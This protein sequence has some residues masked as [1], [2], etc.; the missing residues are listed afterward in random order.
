MS[1]PSRAEVIETL[2][3]LD[4]DR[5]RAESAADDP[6]LAW[7]DDAL[8]ACIDDVVTS[9]SRKINHPGLALWS[10]YLSKGA[11]PPSQAKAKGKQAHT[12]QL[13]RCP[14]P[15]CYA[16]GD[17]SVCRG[18]HGFLRS[19]ACVGCGQ[20]VM[21]CGGCCPVVEVVSVA[22]PARRKARA[23]VQK[24]EEIAV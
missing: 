6:R 17:L 20:N 15:D 22:K 19:L 21:V 9:P 16:G 10:R 13:V 4:V 5:V 3:S 2:I 23:K 18:V 11:F 8:A 14:F 1:E 7:T 24:Q 12:E